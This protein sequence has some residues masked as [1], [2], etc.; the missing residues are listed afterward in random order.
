MLNERIKSV[1]RAVMKKGRA[2]RERICQLSKKGNSDKDTVRSVK[3][4]HATMNTYL[5]SFLTRLE[6]I[7]KTIVKWRRFFFLNRWADSATTFS[8]SNPKNSFENE[9]ENVPNIT[10]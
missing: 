1:N 2:I 7:K 5:N 4:S 8:E 3:I 6:K 10:A 9:R